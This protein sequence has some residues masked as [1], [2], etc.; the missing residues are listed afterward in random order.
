[1]KL[2]HY[3][4]VLVTILSL[5]AIQAVANENIDQITAIANGD[6]RSD[7]YKARNPVPQPGGNP[8]LVRHPRRSD[9]GGNVP[10]AAA[11]TQRYWRRI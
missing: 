3:L 11:G 6:H 8:G 2:K 5:P 10:G 9:G 7:K 4:I 1:M